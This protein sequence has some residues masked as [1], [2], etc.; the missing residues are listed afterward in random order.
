MNGVSIC[1]YCHNTGFVYSNFN[2]VDY[3]LEPDA[4]L[5]SQEHPEIVDPNI[6]IDTDE[7]G[8]WWLWYSNGEVREDGRNNYATMGEPIHYCPNCGRRL[9]KEEK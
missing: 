3:G 6:M 1:K 5:F 8:A 4:L 7:N 2:P 9:G